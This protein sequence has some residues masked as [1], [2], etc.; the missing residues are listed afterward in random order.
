MT[1]RFLLCITISYL[2]LL[3]NNISAETTYDK[4]DI[5]PQLSASLSVKSARIGDI[6]ELSL[7]YT[8]PKDAK[9]SP[10][11][12]I[13]GL[14]D[15]AVIEKKMIPGE[16]L[17]SIIV[18]RQDSFKLGPFSLSFKDKEGEENIIRSEAVTLDLITNLGE[19]P[20][21][22][23]LKPI[24]EIVPITP[25]WLIYLLWSAGGIIVLLIAA[26]IIWWWRK[27]R[28]KNDEIIKERAAHIIAL[29][30]I[31][32]LRKD[33]L[34]EKGRYKEFYFRFSEIL[35]HYLE[36]LRGFPAAEFTTEEIS[37]RITIEED[38]MLIP[39]LREADLVKFADII[40]T[41]AKKDEDIRIAL[42]YIQSTS[43]TPTVIQ[44]KDR[45]IEGEE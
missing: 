45:T 13:E 30:E 16:I 19:K 4:L 18:D 44:Q 28:L 37:R 42:L 1:I 40:P 9:I 24:M 17:L 33:K 22:A 12:K 20:A 29:G 6:V 25:L 23:R 32:D 43:P 15:V 14:K 3:V 21:E 36:R 5:A 35:R 27:K 8:L 26:G 10:E 2:S 7:K 11:S 34:F 38:R 39:M 41:S 31:D